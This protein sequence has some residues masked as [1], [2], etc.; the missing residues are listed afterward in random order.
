MQT[1]HL[2]FCYQAFQI[3]AQAGK[4]TFSYDQ[5]WLT[6]LPAMAE[7]HHQLIMSENTFLLLKIYK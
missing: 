4:T 2:Q 7:G 3:E 1:K 5:T 6:R